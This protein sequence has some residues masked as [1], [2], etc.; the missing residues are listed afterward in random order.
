[1]YVSPLLFLSYSND[2]LHPILLKYET[3]SEILSSMS[4][5]SVI[6][7][8]P[9]NALT[10]VSILLFYNKLLTYSVE[11]LYLFLEFILISLYITR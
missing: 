3:C 10:L 7:Y 5:S 2:I 1:M 9:Y 4:M 11:F 8:F 6:G